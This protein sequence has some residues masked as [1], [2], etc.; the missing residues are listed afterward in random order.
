M[1]LVM[2][3]WHAAGW[4]DT[5]S[6]A[7]CKQRSAVCSVSCRVQRTWG[8]KPMTSWSSKMPQILQERVTACAARAATTFGPTWAA[9][10]RWVRGLSQWGEKKISPSGGK[11]AARNNVGIHEWMKRSFNCN[12]QQFNCNCSQERYLKKISLKCYWYR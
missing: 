1:S 7:C 4:R 11:S 12:Y 9:A 6:I 2:L 8:C 10:L 3:Q 5:G